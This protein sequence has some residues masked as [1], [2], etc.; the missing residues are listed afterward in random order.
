MKLLTATG[1]ALLLSGLTAV[2]WTYELNPSD[3]N[4]NLSP[5]VLLMAF[6]TVA[7]GMVSL[8]LTRIP[9]QRIHVKVIGVCFLIIALSVPVTFLY[10][11]QTA[12][13]GCLGTCR[14]GLPTS[15]TINACNSSGADVVCTLSISNPAYEG[16][17][18]HAT[19]CSIQ[20]G[21]NFTGGETDGVPIGTAGA[22]GGDT[23]LAKSSDTLTCTVPNA[24]PVVGSGLE[25]Q[26][27]LSNGYAIGTEGTWPLG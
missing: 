7:L 17:N 26:V 18:V 11:T 15:I 20:F 5:V 27:G 6:G 24:V 21:G 25:V 12:Q 1:I 2:I 8:Y 22:L 16:L 10:A 13:V 9:L 14:P 3:F 19:A 4:D 23:A